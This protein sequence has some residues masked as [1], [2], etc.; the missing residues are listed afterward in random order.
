[1]VLDI[2]T[3]ITDRGSADPPAASD[4]ENVVPWADLPARA[5][6]SPSPLATPGLDAHLKPC[7]AADLA[8][9]FSGT[10]GATGTS[11]RFITLTNV[12]GTPCLLDARLEDLSGL[13][14][15]RR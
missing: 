5:E 6:P 13:Q 9:E 11:L 4:A 7:R 8:A 3:V 12:G 10:D 15:G 1:M 2:A 14:G